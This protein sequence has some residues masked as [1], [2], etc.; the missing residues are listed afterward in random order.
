MGERS[1]V[2]RCQFCHGRRVLTIPRFGPHRHRVCTRCLE[3]GHR[4]PIRNQPTTKE[5][6]R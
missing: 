6:T 4:H 5:T 3:C 2:K 1:L